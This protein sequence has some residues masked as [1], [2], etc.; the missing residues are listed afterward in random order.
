MDLRKFTKMKIAFRLDGLANKVSI[1][2]Q[3]KFP[4]FVLVR[5]HA[6]PLRAGQTNREHHAV[7]PAVPSPVLHEQKEKHKAGIC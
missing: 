1:E 3:R 5:F 6:E 2:M 7:T 4:A